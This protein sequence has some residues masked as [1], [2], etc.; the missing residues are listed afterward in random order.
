[1]KSLQVSVHSW[2]GADS[3]RLRGGCARPRGLRRACRRAPRRARCCAAALHASP[4][5]GVAAGVCMPNW[6][7]ST[8]LGVRADVAA[9]AALHACACCA[10][11]RRTARCALL[12]INP[13]ASSMHPSSIQVCHEHFHLN[14][15]V[16]MAD[17]ARACGSLLLGVCFG[18]Q[19]FAVFCACAIKREQSAFMLR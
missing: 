6:A 1:M 14:A 19:C 8:L 16:E 7:F 13:H 5:A 18:R 3:R 17:Q 9:S 10:V 15:S 4:G 11:R 12:S 2:T